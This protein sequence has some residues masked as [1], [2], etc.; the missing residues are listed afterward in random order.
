MIITGLFLT[1][2]SL[3]QSQKIPFAMQINKLFADGAYLSEI[4]N[5]NLQLPSDINAG[6]IEKYFKIGDVFIALVLRNSMNVVLSLPKGFIPS[7][8]GILA[9]REDDTK[10]NKWVEIKDE[11]P[12]DKNN[13]YRFDAPNGKL[14]LTV[15]DQN[16]AGSGEGIMKVFSLDDTGNW[17]LDDCSY[18][19]AGGYGVEPPKLEP[20]S[21]ECK[22]IQLLTGN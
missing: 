9:A 17:N 15:I 19:T 2:C 12:T 14:L 5:P 20:T 6:Q 7:F 1:S 16:G 3:P 13:P 21:T 10:W 22:N 18:Y 4:D 8:A 11:K